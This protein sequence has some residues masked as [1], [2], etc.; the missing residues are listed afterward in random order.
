MKQ[1]DLIIDSIS[2]MDS[3]ML[4]NVLDDNLTYQ[5]TSKDIFIEKIEEAFCEFKELKDNKLLPIAGICNSTVCTNKGCKGYSFFG[6]VSG[7]TL[8]LIFDEHNGKIQDVYYCNEMKN[9]L[10]VTEYEDKI[11]IKI[12]FDENVNFKPSVQYLINLQKAQEAFDEIKSYKGLIFSKDDISYLTEKFQPL[13]DEVWDP[14][15]G[16][17]GFDKFTGIFDLLNDINK[18]IGKEK[19]IENA[20]SEYDSM[21]MDHEDRFLIHWL[22]KF[23]DLGLDTIPMTYRIDQDE[24]VNLKIEIINVGYKA[25]IRIKRSEFKNELLFCILF[26]KKYFDFIDRNRSK[27]TEKEEIDR[28]NKGLNSKLADFVDLSIFGIYP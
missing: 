10:K 14:F 6:N 11:R 15:N 9:E 23:E 5:D 13:Y 21:T 7:S 25:K 3:E 4:S 26:N 24:L 22:L 8:D 2:K 27:L 18:H 19:N 28:I 1:K 16:Y 12:G 20:L 17:T